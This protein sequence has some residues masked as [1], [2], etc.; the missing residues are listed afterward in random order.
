[1]VVLGG[2]AVSYE[3]GTPVVVWRV[4]FWVEGLGD[5]RVRPQTASEQRANNC[6]GSEAGSYLRLIDFVY[7][8]TLGLRVIKKKK[9]NQ[10]FKD[11]YLEAK[12][13]IWP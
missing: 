4:G 5:P 3:R 2:G 12:A 6:S 8:S 13:R 1:M 9:K 7:H 11:F 10:T